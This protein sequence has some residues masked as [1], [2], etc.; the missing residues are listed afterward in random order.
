MSTSSR[1]P[2]CQIAAELPPCPHR[3][4]VSPQSRHRGKRCLKC[5]NPTFL[6]PVCVA[7]QSVTYFWCIFMLGRVVCKGS[8]P[9]WPM[10]AGSLHLKIPRNLQGRLCQGRLVVSNLSILAHDC[11]LKSPAF[12][13]GRVGRLQRLPR[14]N[15]CSHLPSRYVGL[16]DEQLKDNI[17]KHYMFSCLLYYRTKNGKI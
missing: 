13:F 12:S 5:E 9:L 11:P 16:M 8:M 15:I 4:S 7:S 1:Y 14:C 6:W 10:E 17:L 2:K 3:L